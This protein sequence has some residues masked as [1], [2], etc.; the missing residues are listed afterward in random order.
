MSTATAPLTWAQRL[1]QVPLDAW[2][3]RAQN[4]T[5]TGECWHMRE[6]GLWAGRR[7]PVCL[8]MALAMT[9]ALL[10]P[11][12]R[13]NAETGGVTLNQFERLFIA[14][15]SEPPVGVQHGWQPVSLKDVWGQE[16]RARHRE[17][18]YRTT[19][20]VGHDGELG[21]FVA[22]IS[23]NAS[24]WLNGQ[25]LGNTG[26]FTDPLPRNWNHPIYL[27]IPPQWVRPGAN[28]LYV[29][30]MVDQ[31]RLGL[32]YEIDVGPREQLAARYGRSYFAKV[33]ASQILTGLMLTSVA[34]VLAFWFT[35]GLPHS[36]LWFALGSLC[37]GLY[38][39]ELFVRHVPMP[40]D[41]WQLFYSSMLLSAAYF[42][43]K[44]MHVVLD[45]E[46][47]WVER[48]VL[49]VLAGNALLF[50]APVVPVTFGL[51]MLVQA[52]IVIWLAYAGTTLLVVGLRRRTEHRAWIVFTGITVLTLTG[53]DG[54]MAVLRITADFAKFPYVP[55]AAFIAGGSV[56]VRRLIETARD[57]DRLRS[58]LAATRTHEAS[59]VTAE[60]TRLMREI[61]DGVGN[62]LVSTLARLEQSPSADL[63]LLRSLRTSLED[64][65]LIVH[66]LQS[67]AQEGDVATL[68]ATI[69]E[70]V[71]PGL[72]A[73]GIV[74]DWQ[75]RPL[76]NVERFDSEQALQLMRLVQEAIT[77]VIKHAR[78]TRIRMA[79][80][81]ESRDGR[82]G[83]FVQ[84]DDDGCGFDPLRPSA[85]VGLGN[86]RHRALRLQ[87]AIDITPSAAGT[88]IRL[89]L[90]IEGS[91]G[92]PAPHPGARASAE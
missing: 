56:F 53:Y 16:R 29:R 79:C 62:Q 8:L 90:P 59:A 82:R 78:A 23:A 52:A 2:V 80:G 75:V 27:P 10:F 84:I 48:V 74:F 60:R 65:R 9:L 85:G 40:S 54:V 22:R 44:T 25:E 46:R 12:G 33:A 5:V 17:A 81:E 86:M 26:P 45:L 50:F 47:R 72:N 57:Q 89:W 41:V 73:Q 34:V 64:L 4:R 87:G 58:Q 7:G 14:D 35:T 92:R 76:P 67:M 42:Y 19:F 18:W 24:F 31:S 61:H 36:Y 30:L 11:A 68:L 21:L 38:S 91:P 51:R 49:G 1:K 83:I 55:L 63:E 37:W 77:N 3:G 66:S 13:A 43:S 70:R 32:L 15:A 28:V 88:K 69:R 71:E 20:D 6:I 39:F